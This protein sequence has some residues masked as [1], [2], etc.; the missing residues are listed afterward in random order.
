MIV[1]N[2]MRDG[3]T[4]LGPLDNCT[5]K[6]FDNLEQVFNEQTEQRNLARLPPRTFGAIRPNFRKVRQLSRLT[7]V[8][9]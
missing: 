4:P 9:N 3:S 2:F 5:F 1:Y 7:L 6:G 8:V